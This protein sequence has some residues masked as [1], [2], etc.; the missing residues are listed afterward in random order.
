MLPTNGAPAQPIR[1][2]VFD[3]RGTLVSE[4]TPRGWAREALRRT[5][6]ACPVEAVDDLLARIKTAAGQPN[7]LQ[8]P[9]GNISYQHHR[10]T[11]YEVFGKA[12]LPDD[13]ADA[14]FEVESDPGLNEFAVDVA[15]TLTALRDNGFQIGILS[16]IHFD[17][18]PAFRDAGLLDLIDVF[19][20][21]SEEGVQKPDPAIF[22]RALTKL[23]TAAAETLMVGDRPSRDGVAVDIGMPTLLVPR[24]TDPTQRRLHLVTRMVDVNVENPCP[25]AQLVTDTALIS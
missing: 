1:A 17:I 24:L 16:N 25:T 3:W 13:L 22:E 14:L 23:R 21:S 8:S 5:G 6:R 12:D 18:R 2:V 15:P 11:Y 10:D 19:V 9:R 20:L 4:L 7:R